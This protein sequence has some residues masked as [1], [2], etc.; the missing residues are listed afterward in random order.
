[1]RILL[2]AGG[3]VENW[4]DLD[5]PFDYYVGIDRG[6]LFLHDHQLPVHLAVGDFD[7]L[8]KSEREKI[9]SIAEKKITAPAEKDDTDTQLAL[10]EVLKKAPHASFT[11]IGATGGRLDHFLSNLWLALEPRFCP[12]CENISIKDKQNTIRFLKAGTHIV[13]KEPDKK[14][15]AYCC[16]TP[17]SDLTLTKSKYTLH[18]QEV[19][20]PTAYPSNEFLDDSA[21]ITFKTGIVAVIQSKDR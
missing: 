4:P 1:M 5:H 13:H 2:V 12:V 7:S 14:Y 19:I 21:E 11:L 8:K 15:L 10:A 9:F 6:S 16:L 17:I 18:H 20:Q 3:P